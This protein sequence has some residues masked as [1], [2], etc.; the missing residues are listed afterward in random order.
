MG[1]FKVNWKP[2]DKT[3][4]E[5]LFDAIFREVRNKAK[6]RPLKM[7]TLGSIGKP[8]KAVKRVNPYTGI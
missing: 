1:K 6:V 2:K 4:E 5:L 7:P 3:P 8:K